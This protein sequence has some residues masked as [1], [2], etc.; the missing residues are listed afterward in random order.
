MGNF[1]DRD[2]CSIRERSVPLMKETIID[3]FIYVKQPGFIGNDQLKI[4]SNRLPR[5]LLITSGKPC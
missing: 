5:V 2:L 3:G 1:G 4:I